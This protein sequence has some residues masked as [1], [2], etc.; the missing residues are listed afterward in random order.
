MA[1]SARLPKEKKEKVKFSCSCGKRYR[2][3][4]TKVGKRITCKACGEKVKVP[5]R[6]ETAVSD[7]SRKDILAGLGIDPLAAAQ[8]YEQ[9]VERRRPKRVYRCTRCVGELEP[10]ELKGAYIQGELVCNGCRAT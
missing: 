3:P 7:R 10:S 8:A 6:R 9:E 5:G 4:K 2:V 1:T